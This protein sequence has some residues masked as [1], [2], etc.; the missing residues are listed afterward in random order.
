MR[1]DVFRVTGVDERPGLG[2]LLVLASIRRRSVSNDQ[3]L[4]AVAV[5]VAAAV[6]QQ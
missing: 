3:R 2:Q 6:K 5:A 1:S 4:E